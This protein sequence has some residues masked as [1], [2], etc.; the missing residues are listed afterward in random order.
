[1]DSKEIHRAIRNKFNLKRRMD[2]LPHG[3]S[4]RFNRNHLA[5][6]LGELKYNKGAEIGV[7]RGRYSMILCR[8]NPD[9][10]LTCVDGWHPY[11][12][13]Y[14]KERQDRIYG[15]AVENL[16][17]YNV[18][19]LRKKSMDALNE[20]ED[21]SLDF[22]C[23]DG[24]HKFDY[25]CPDIIFWSQKVRKNGIVACHD[26]YGFGWSGVMKAVDAYTFCH[27]I[28]PWYVTKELE[29]TAFWVKPK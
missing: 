16:S 15:E 26:Y 20:F 14:N 24:N 4:R 23:I 19:I 2:N 13:K 6:L 10:H 21:G 22:V 28:D 11:D 1:M 8:N 29:P 5:E 25:V 12:R 18:T 9:L 17:S 7:R 27:H 3:A